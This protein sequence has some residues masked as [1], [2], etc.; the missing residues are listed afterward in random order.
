MDSL[1]WRWV[2]LNAVLATAVINVLANGLIAWLSVLGMDEV[3]MWS[4]PL[5]GGTS[6][7][8]DTLGTFFVLPFL[9]MIFTTLAIRREMRLGAFT[10]VARADDRAPLMRKLPQR[11]GRRALAFA[12]LMTL[13]FGLLTLVFVLAFAPETMSTSAFITYKIVLGALL[14]ALVTP[15]VALG[16]MADQRPTLQGSGAGRT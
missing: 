13:T 15:V 1:H 9:T 8:V 14:G 5:V 16:A 3:P 6:T 7:A 4:V 10:P 11:L 2:W 12:C